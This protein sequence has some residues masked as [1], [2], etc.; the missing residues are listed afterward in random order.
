MPLYEYECAACGERLERLQKMGEAPLVECPACGESALRRLVSRPAFQFKGSGW[1]V[2]DY[3]RKGGEKGKEREAAEAK[4]G[5]E[6]KAGNGEKAKKHEGEK[7]DKKETK[8][9]APAKAAPKGES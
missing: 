5:D 6:A 7:K 4:A 3:A 2:T 1:Y 9:A 8:E